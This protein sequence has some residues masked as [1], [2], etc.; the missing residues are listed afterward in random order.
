[1]GTL[2]SKYRRAS[3]KH[4]KINNQEDIEMPGVVHG[5]V[6]LLPLSRGTVIRY[7]ANG[8]V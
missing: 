1:M 2:T 6:A 4:I 3:L 8:E 7:K 5:V